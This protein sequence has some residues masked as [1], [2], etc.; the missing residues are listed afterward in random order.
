ML[1]KKFCFVNGEKLDKLIDYILNIKNLEAILLTGE[2]GVG[3]TTLTSQIAKKL[4]ETKA[5]ISPTFNTIIVYDK[6]V[7]IDAYK[8]KGDL[9]AY[10][11]Y[12][13][14]KLVIIEWANNVKT[15]F[16]KFLEINVTLDLKGNHIFEIMKEVY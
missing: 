9:F 4:G 13:E 1:T 8:L 14:N 12:F 6:L 2:L 7:H 16:R 3:K 10:E 11:D 5:I 15:N